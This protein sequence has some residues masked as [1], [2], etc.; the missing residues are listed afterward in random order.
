M[1]EIQ[2]IKIDVGDSVICDFCDK[3]FTGEE[4]S[5]GLIFTSNAVCPDC[6]PR[7]LNTIR[8]YNEERFIKAYCPENKSFHQFV[9]DYRKR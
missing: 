5:G 8:G 4:I 1:Q 9:L 3:D 6:S 7:Q 2:V